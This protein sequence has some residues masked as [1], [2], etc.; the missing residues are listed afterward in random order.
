MHSEDYEPTTD[1]VEVKNFIDKFGG[2]F[3]IEVVTDVV[4]YEDED[5]EWYNTPKTKQQFFGMLVKSTEQNT[6]LFL[7]SRYKDDYPPGAYI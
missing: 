4:Y 2:L 3:M 7:K 1:D 6:N 5:G